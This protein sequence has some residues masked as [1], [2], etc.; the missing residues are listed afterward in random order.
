MIFDGIIRNI[1]LRYRGTYLVPF[2]VLSTSLSGLGAEFLPR[3]LKEEIWVH[4][5]NH[6]GVA[7]EFALEYIDGEAANACDIKL[8]LLLETHVILTFY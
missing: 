4:L 3:I 2:G 6:L 8:L 1:V 5:P 7:E